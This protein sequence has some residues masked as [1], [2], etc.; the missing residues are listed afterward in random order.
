MTTLDWAL[1]YASMGLKVFPVKPGTKGDRIRNAE[2]KVIASGQ[3]LASWK[4]EATTDSKIIK[5]WWA[6][7]PNADVCIATGGGLTVIDMDVKH[8]PINGIETALDWQMQNKFFPQTAKTETGSGGQHLFYWTSGSTFKSVQSEKFRPGIDIKSEGGYVVAPPSTNGAGMYKWLNDTF[9]AEANDAVLSFLMNKDIKGKPMKE[10]LE[11]SRNNT[12]RDQV[13]KLVHDYNDKEEVLQLALAMNQE[14]VPPEDETIV[15]QMVERAFNKVQGE[16]TAD[17]INMEDVEPEE[18]EWLWYPYIPRAKLTIIAGEAG[19]GKTFLE[20]ALAAIISTGRPFPGEDEWRKPEIV[21]IQNTE[22]GLADTIV[23]RLIAAGADRKMIKVIKTDDEPLIFSSP[24][25]EDFMKRFRPAMMVFDPFQSFFGAGIDL[26]RSNE[27]RPVFDR[28]LHLAQK[29][30]VAVVLVMHLSKMTNASGINRVLGSVDIV[31]AVRSVLIIAK[32]P[33][34]DSQKVIAHEKSNLA[35]RGESIVYHI[36]NGAVQWDGFCGLMADDCLNKGKQKNEVTKLQQATNLIESRLKVCGKVS[37]REL[38]E[39]AEEMGISFK[40]F[41]R[42][43]VNLG[44]IEQKEDFI[45]D[46]FWTVP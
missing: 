37:A 4:K 38:R 41:Q 10:T 40:T 32:H 14:C 17:I 39:L 2:G 20:T 36:E 5:G 46:T 26:N 33:N 43:K 31:G 19:I 7:W 28:L 29:Y 45:G 11:G 18:V 12:L 16:K 42:A 34:V 22:D 23:K 44:L 9:I 25:I 21:C 6:K 24:K 13:W 3:L 35:P 27:T 1:K 30:N 15:T 8:P